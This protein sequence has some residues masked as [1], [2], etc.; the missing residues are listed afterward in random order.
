M[1][2]RIWFVG[3]S[4]KP[5]VAAAAVAVSLAATAVEVT[6]E[7]A[8]TAARNWVRRS[9]VQMT[10]KF[11]SSEVR[12]AQAVK[13]DDGKALYHVVELD[14]GGY[15]VTS[16]DTELPPVIA[17]SAS[18]TIDLSDSGNPLVALLERDLKGRRAQIA[19]PQ[20]KMLAVQPDPDDGATA[21][22]AEGEWELLLKEPEPKKK[23][24][25]VISVKTA[26][27]SGISD[28]RVAPL[29]QSKWNQSTWNGY[30][31][32]NYYTPNN[33]VCGCVATAFAQIMR[34]WQAPSGSVSAGTSTCWV[35]YKKT[36]KTM[37]GGT[38]NWSSMPLTA[39]GCTTDA[40]RQ[41][42]GKLLYDVGV[43]AQMGWSSGGSG[44]L[45][46]IAAQALRHRFGYASAHSYGGGYS[47]TLS[48]NLASNGDF[49]NAILASL[50]AGMPVA[51][52]VTSSRSGHEV[53]VDGY[54]YNGSSLV[55]CHI[56]CGWGGS[57]DA[58]YNLIGEGI[59]SFGYTLM[60]EVA[61]NIHPTESGDIISGRVLDVSGS[62]VPE[63]TVTL[64]PE[65]GS[66]QTATANAKGIYW[67]RAAANAQYALV[68]SYGGLTS[69]VQVVSLPQSY[70]TEYE[71]TEMNS[72]GSVS[73]TQSPTSDPYPDGKL[74]NKWGVNLM[75]GSSSPQ[76][77][78]PLAAALDNSDLAFTTGG[79]AS[80]YGQTAIS[81]D[82]VAAAR[83]GDV[84][85]G[86]CTWL[87]TSVTGPGVLSFYWNVSCE[88]DASH[89]D[90]DYLNVSIDGEELARI[91]GT[92]NEWTQMACSIPT[93]THTVR[94]QYNKDAD[95]SGGDDAA[96][97]DQVV[98]MPAAMTDDPYDPG[99]DTP[100]GGTVIEPSDSL[101]THDGHTLSYTDKYDFFKVDLSA[102]YRYVFETTGSMDTYGN[103]FD[104]T[105]LANS[106]ACNDDSGDSRNF[107]IEYAPESSGTYYLRVRAFSLGTAGSYSLA[108]QR[109]VADS[110]GATVKPD[111]VPYAPS[112]WSSP[113]VVASSNL[114]K[115][116]A[117]TFSKDD[118][119]YVSWAVICRNADISATFYS[120]L[121]IDGSLVKSWYTEGLPKNYYSWVGGRL[122]G[123]L[124]PGT[125]VI[126]I[127]HDQTGIVAESNESNNTVETAVAVTVN[128]LPNL[129]VVK[130][131]CSK[132]AIALSETLTVHW[133]VANK[134]P[135]AAKKTKTAFE[136]WKYD[137][138]GD[139]WTLKK[140]DWLDCIPLAA[141]AGREYTRSITGASLGT[142]RY[143]IRIR[144]DGTGAVLEDDESDNYTDTYAF[145]VAKDIATRSKS[146][147]DWQFR[148]I[149]GEPDSFY[150]GKSAKAKKKATTFRVGQPI[151]MRCCWW[152]AMKG[153]VSGKMRIRVILNGMVGIYSERS[154]F[155]KNS[156]YCLTDRTPSFLQNLPA[157][158]YTLTA[159][160]DSENDWMETNE[161]N[162]IRR[163]SF[164]VVEAPTIY[165]ESTY[166]C[167]LNE[168]VRWPV[169][170]EGL[171]T[172]K[173]LPPGLKYSGGTIVGKAKKRGTYFAKFTA[174]NAAGTRTRT[175]TIKVIN[176][177]F[178][179]DVNVRANG[180]TGATPVASGGTVPMYMGVDQKIT[181][182]STPGKSGI[183][184]SGA[185]SVKVSGLPPGLK[186]AKG[187]ISGV[188]S[189]TGTYTVKLV[190]KNALGWSKSFTM[191]MQVMAL[192][193]FACG[194]FYGWTYRVETG[195]QD[196]DVYTAVRKV[197][198]SVTTAGKITAKA[199]TLSF[200]R[201]GWTVGEDGFYTATMR[202]VRTVGKGKKAKKYTDVLTLRLDPDA[203]W[204]TDQLTGT[205]ATF[206]GNV[207]LADALVALNGGESAPVPLN[208]DNYVSARRNPFG[209]N[210]EAKA[211]AAE[212][213]ALG[214]QTLTDVDGLVWNIKVSTSGVAT[215]ARTTGSGKN[216]KTVSA[217]A[218]VA[219][220]GGDYGP[221][222][223]FLVDGKIIEVQ[224]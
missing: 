61:Y 67:F 9:P 186:Y 142:G 147:V 165:G 216:R 20:V 195:A 25:D 79:S 166:T 136:I 2:S 203:V 28:V 40:Q 145:T 12:H 157:G 211:L 209:D 180:A 48:S 80:W 24:G 125:H 82:W 117:T 53:V 154:Y 74:G 21:Y 138:S 179:V 64:T 123:K 100:G 115:E 55:Y 96:Y 175:V 205:V 89:Q 217:T 132:E 146:T 93:G 173:G 98:W 110:G 104:S 8:Q 162:N 49:R 220:N 208:A 60:D 172:V 47:G 221:Y 167:A 76:F 181:V 90:L 176:P 185:S 114:S 143:V 196:A 150:L 42:I 191:K 103:L 160:L 105:T 86:Q 71:I 35:D 187:V 37:Y 29:L 18:G 189:R 15:V 120:R 65:S 46:C 148:K 109:F 139:A 178:K 128:R 152:N 213:V 1:A 38:Y 188:P 63:A 174:K 112:G 210:A 137:P 116:G 206:N 135:T 36:S 111:L 121:Y 51:I 223:I 207:A 57:E 4:L 88:G 69:A 144:A 23:S 197:T 34:Y 199:G 177:G 183:A 108:Y 215:I 113:L 161:K 32:F 151:Y 91:C 153:A 56:N 102:G 214:S 127:V 81:H 212:L 202:T 190:F 11:K 95:G 192:P 101:A 41:A 164:T 222:A 155:S 75:L 19:K 54:G 97:V 85:D 224:W 58:W 83:S 119:L 30:N 5:L 134:G 118:S 133:R 43:A 31:T 70:D 170:S 198:A 39:D 17:F 10:A 141:G 52:G 158:K 59:T 156:W 168:S 77:S 6:T 3:G 50:D 106:I 99:D 126:R 131:N 204:T 159:M 184:K 27:Y 72:D 78:I 200:S 26:S 140:T 130:A 87:E 169:S 84:E 62:P 219:W 68:A 122:I 22:A 33:Y 194:T 171:M 66:P 73:Y 129:Q 193:A 16:G 218:V 163:I 149:Q 13:A 124:A 7:Q 45:G 94:W 201:T 44:T 14:G 182:A 92:D 107:K